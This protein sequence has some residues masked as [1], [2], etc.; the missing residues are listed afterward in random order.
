MYRNG[1]VPFMDLAKGTFWLGLSKGT[2]CAAFHADE[3]VD[4]LRA[5]L[6]SKGRAPGPLLFTMRM[7]IIKRTS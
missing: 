1:N 7:D 2:S 6:A 5:L 3:G 4:K